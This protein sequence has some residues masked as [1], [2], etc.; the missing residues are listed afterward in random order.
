MASDENKFG[1][2]FVNVSPSSMVGPGEYRFKD[3]R[4]SILS[5]SAQVH[6]RAGDLVGFFPTV[7]AITFTPNEDA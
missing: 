6:N 7:A 2:V 4:F 1:T 5:E 3:S